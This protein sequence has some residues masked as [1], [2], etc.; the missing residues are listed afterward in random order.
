M[1][2]KISFWFAL[3]L[4]LWICTPEQAATQT[5][6]QPTSVAGT[7]RI[8]RSPD[9]FSFSFYLN[10]IPLYRYNMGSK[11]SDRGNLNGLTAS[12][13]GKNY[14]IP[15]MC[16]GILVADSERIVYPCE[17][18]VVYKLE[19]QFIRSDS[20]ALFWRVSLNDREVYKYWMSMQ[21]KGKTLV[22]DIAGIGN[23]G[24]GVMLG[25]GY[26]TR[27]DFVVVPV[28]YLPITCILYQKT[29][30]GFTSMFFD[31][32]KTNCSRML[33]AASKSKPVLFTSPAEYF[34]RTDGRRNKIKERIY[35]TTSLDI[36]EVLPNVVAPVAP[37][38]SKLQDKIIISYHPPFPTLLEPL[39]PN[40]SLPSYLDSLKKLGITNVALLVKDW[41]WSGFD[42]GNPR[43]LPANDFHMAYKQL[44]KTGNDIMLKVRD[45][46]HSLGY[47]M[48][49]HQNYVD[50]YSGSKAGGFPDI[51]VNYLVVSKLPGTENRPAWAYVS[52]NSDENAWAIKPSLVFDIAR[53]VS[54][55]IYKAYRTDWN[56]LD[57]TSA[58]N[59]SGPLAVPQHGT[60]SS[61]VD[62]DASPGSA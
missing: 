39:I 14:F 26:T 13:D 20:V 5:A 16:G 61:Y 37:F 9:G 29:T 38:K 51:P 36:E 52:E 50:V 18:G 46:V 45:K 56:Y 3:V 21:I 24:A 34:P 55:A 27:D 22:I 1:I 23:N 58:L 41:W 10:N 30:R 44:G 11:G 42:K 33:P 2:E 57:V 12:I 60:V 25:E 17:T 32:E 62:F 7:N 6:P 49:L 43:V 31:W 19:N 35:L 4:T 8:E 47:T 28:P 59:P 54:A 40:T 53:R 15:A 48:A